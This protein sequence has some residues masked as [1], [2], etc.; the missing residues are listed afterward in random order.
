VDRYPRT[1]AALPA[2]PAPAALPAPPAPAALPAPPTSAA[3]PAPRNPPR[4]SPPARPAEEAQGSFRPGRPPLG[5]RPALGRCPRRPR[6]VRPCRKAG[7]AQK[8]TPCPKAEPTRKTGSRRAKRRGRTPLCRAAMRHSAR[9]RCRPSGRTR[10]SPLR[11][12]IGMISTVS[13]KTVSRFVRSVERNGEVRCP[14]IAKGPAAAAYWA[15]IFPTWQPGGADSGEVKRRDH[16]GSSTGRPSPG[17][18][19]GNR[20]G[21]RRRS[22]GPFTQ[23]PNLCSSRPQL[24]D[25]GRDRP[26][27]KIPACD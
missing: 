1:P 19:D 8:S 7:P 23:I 26:V 6:K 9:A 22:H 2:P 14:D 3:L 4:A 20:A 17:T 5:N 13:S 16:D 11:S 10:S 12:V 21:R 15:L 18:R 27:T 25:G 24:L